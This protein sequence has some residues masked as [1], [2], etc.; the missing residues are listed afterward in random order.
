MF[1]PWSVLPR[2]MARRR[3]LA[4]PEGSQLAN[5]HRRVLQSNEYFPS[6]PDRA[7]SG[8]R[9]LSCWTWEMLPSS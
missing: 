9:R 2:Q 1:S 6:L 8:Y 3:V 5:V 7:G 4:L